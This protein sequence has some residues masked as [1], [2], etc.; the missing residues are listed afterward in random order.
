MRGEWLLI[1]CPMWIL[2][3]LLVACAAA[4][5][6]PSATSTSAGSATPPTPVGY[7]EGK[8]TIGPLRPAQRV[9][10][11]AGPVPPEAYAAY[12]IKIFKSDGATW[13]ADVKVRPDG[14]YQIALAPDT[15]VVARTGAGVRTGRSPDLPKTVT[16]LGG[17][18]MRLDIYIDTGIR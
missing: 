11:P 3:L 5:P 2:G 13:V 17:Q 15:Y 9:D 10:E 1:G 8:V 16:I 12:P 18:M 14:T 4:T 6:Q 7:L